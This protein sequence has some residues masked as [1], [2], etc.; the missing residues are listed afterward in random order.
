MIEETYDRGSVRIPIRVLVTRA[1]LPTGVNPVTR[2]VIDGWIQRIRNTLDILPIPH[3][4]LL[5]GGPNG[6]IL[7]GRPERGGGALPLGAA[8][9]A[10]FIHMSYECFGDSFN[11]RGNLSYTFLHEM[12]HL[13]DHWEQGHCAGSPRRCMDYLP[14]LDPLG[15]LAMLRRYHGGGTRWTSEHYADVYA[16][17]W[18]NEVSGIDYSINRAEPGWRC[19]RTCL[20]LD[21]RLDAEI[22]RMGL[23]YPGTA[24]D[25][26][27]HRRTSLRYDALF[28]S[29]PFAGIVRQGS[30]RDP[31]PQPSSPTAAV[32]QG[33]APSARFGMSGPSVAGPPAPLRQRKPLGLA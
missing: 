13:V 5:A 16:D 21:G 20:S 22:R 30:H 7:I 3:I 2:N 27:N 14:A 32:N 8:R 24:T 4:A 19:V 18:Y 1:E 15:C 9:T 12:G 11:R 31:R 25:A 6:H 23:S 26:D 29:V 28:R 33:I 10:P 17:Y